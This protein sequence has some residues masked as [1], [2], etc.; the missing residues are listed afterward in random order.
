M[1]ERTCIGC[2]N[3]FV[4]ENVRKKRCRDQCGIMNRSRAK[5]D[6]L[7]ND[8]DFIGVD[9]EGVDRPNGDHDYVMLSVGAETLWKQGRKLDPAE[10][11][12]FLWEQYCLN[13]ESAFVGFFLGYD[14]IQ[15]LKLLPK[16]VGRFLLT[17]EGIAERTSKAFKS[18]KVVYPDAVVWNGWE[19]DIMGGKRFKIR[20]HAHTKSKFDWKF[21][22]NKTCKADL[23]SNA[24]VLDY[25]GPKI[26]KWMSICDTGS[27]WQ[28]S[29]L[30]VIDPKQWGDNPV[31]TAEQYATVKQGKSERGT[32]A[33][34]DD[35][36]YFEDMQRY[37][38]LENELLSRV[39]QRLN[40]GF[41]N[42][43]IPIKLNKNDWYGPGRAAQKWIDM[44]HARVANPQAVEWNK[45]N[46]P[47]KNE[48]GI[49]NADVY[50]SMPA[51]FYTASQAS[52][53]GGWFE[54]MVHGHCGDVWEYDINSAYPYIIASLPCLHTSG[55]HNGTYA[56]ADDS[57][58]PP[59]GANRFTLLYGTFQ[60]SNSYIGALP[61]RTPQ[62][63]ILRPNLTKGWY[64]L[65]EIEAAQ[66]ARLI[67]IIEV[68][69][70]VSYEACECPPPFNPDGIGIVAMYLLRLS[71]GKNS[72]L[73]KALKL[74]YNSAYG[75]TAQSIG[76][77][78]YS[79]PMYASLITA[80]CR[81][82]ILDAIA[83]H[84]EGARAVTMV[85]TDGIYFTSK[86]PGLDM[87]KARLGA[88]DE[89]FKQDMCQLM[90]GVYWDEET[91]KSIG[92]GGAPKLK[93][94]GVSAGDLAKEIAQLDNLFARAHN[95]LGTGGEYVWPEANFPIKFTITSA[96]AALA[97]GKWD[98]AGKVEH[99][100][101]RRI[102]ANPT[103]KRIPKAYADKKGREQALTRT[104]V[105]P[106]GP[107]LCSVP[108]AKAFGYT[109]DETP[110]TRDGGFTTPDAREQ[111]NL[112]E[113]ID[114][115]NS[116]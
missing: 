51:W 62:G 67:D 55:G 37:N 56:Q 27:F 104:P 20:P 53:Y 47:R 17:K 79:N 96:K 13:P 58:Y 43:H 31:C 22:T 94:R 95:T 8:L 4:T 24:H 33:A 23:T 92:L 114:L 106:S 66:R 15:W 90:P 39:T 21:C 68:E 60:G 78:K 7:S 26:K 29:F 113:Y 69:K 111:L 75:K 100:K 41:M 49:L 72:V 109:D 28:A 38:V 42:E 61:H 40:L 52:Y 84:P 19:I 54:Q 107:A 105:Y 112:Q 80:G 74:V 116:L 91:R 30:K 76:N 85:A 103:S 73:G 6:P 82:M 115:L 89:T 99:G 32:V 34:V 12:E 98:D 1:Y 3:E 70:W 14:F 86:H 45:K 50:S 108:Y 10:I 101:D 97:R 102:S 87:D 9:G 65:H 88:W 44:L 35:V 46:E 25:S 36:S 81:T 5:A 71:A 18:K 110:F 59:S 83:S 11:F 63:N 77:P 2:G 16:D 64:W 48:G 57:E 93:S